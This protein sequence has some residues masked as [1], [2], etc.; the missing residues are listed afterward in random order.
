MVWLL[1]PSRAN[2]YPQFQ[3]STENSR[4]SL[5]HFSPVGGGLVNAWGKE[6]AADT[7][8]RGGNGA[9][10][11]GL[12]TP[13]SWL[14]LGGDFRGVALAHDTPSQ[15]VDLLL[16]PMQADLY[17]RVAAGPISIVASAGLRRPARAKKPPTRSYFASRE[18]YVQYRPKASGLYLR[19]GKFYAPY[20]L[21]GADHTSY[22]RRDL[23]FYADEQTYGVSGGYLAD[24]ASEFHLSVFTRDP[25]TK[26]GAQG[27][28]IA[29]LYERRFADNTAAWGVQSK[30]HLGPDSQSYWLGGTLK[31]WIPSARLLV[32]YEANLGMKNV[33][34]EGSQAIYQAIAHL[35]ATHFVTKGV[36]LGA[37]I[38]A[39]QSDFRLRGKDAESAS[40]SLQY[41]PKAHYEIELLGKAERTRETHDLTS[42]L[43]FHY[44][45]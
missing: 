15:G 34:A 8:S 6:E 32:L 31:Y 25:I 42:L 35:N 39:K 24:N 11:Q 2:A 26:V 22:V 7:I 36:M 3:F 17:T 40:A 19:A 13:P 28:G 41:F 9:F 12:W 27:S 18:H 5:C 16:F 10:L 29:A 33:D 44:Y 43:M 30:L 23:G 45:L 37:T 38:E 20:G 1:C 21:R 4:C 14:S